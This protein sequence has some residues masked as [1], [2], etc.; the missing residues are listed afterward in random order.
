[1]RGSRYLV[2]SRSIQSGVSTTAARRPSI[3][4]KAVLLSGQSPESNRLR[5]GHWQG[6]P[7]QTGPPSPR[8][9]FLRALNHLG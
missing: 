7:G 8:R 2:A 5:A 9:L 3:P 6:E 1:M 4:C